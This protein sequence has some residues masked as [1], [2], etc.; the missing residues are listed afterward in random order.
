MVLKIY[1]IKL[2]VVLVILMN[3]LTKMPYEYSVLYA[4]Q[5][6]SHLQL[7]KT[8][9]LQYINKNNYYTI[10]QKNAFIMNGLVS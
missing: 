8:L 2:Y 1:N 6:D 7:R 4:L 3:A 5:E 9:Q 10:S